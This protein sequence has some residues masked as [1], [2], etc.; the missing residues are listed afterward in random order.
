MCFSSSYYAS[1]SRSCYKLLP[2]PTRLL[3]MAEHTAFSTSGEDAITRRIDVKVDTTAD[4]LAAGE[5]DQFY[6][7]ERTTAELIEG[8]Y[9]RVSNVLSSNVG[10]FMTM[11]IR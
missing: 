9:K 11:F 5:F 1:T 4:Q 7:I 2:L 8:D 3:F 10:A 6:E